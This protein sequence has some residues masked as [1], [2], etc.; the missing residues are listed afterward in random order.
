M[1]GP[2]VL[3]ALLRAEYLRGLPRAFGNGRR[4]DLLLVPV[5]QEPE[6]Q[7]AALGDLEGR[8]VDSGNASG[9]HSLRGPIVKVPCYLA[10]LH[11]LLL[12]F[13]G[14]GLDERPL[15]RGLLRV[16]LVDNYL[17]LVPVLAV[18]RRPVRIPVIGVR[19]DWPDLWQRA[20]VDAHHREGLDVPSV[21]D[22]LA[23]KYAVAIGAAEAKGGN[24][25]VACGVMHPGALRLE[26]GVKR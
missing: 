15:D 22:A 13:F 1:D 8:N 12:A 3:R 4:D 19:P 20:L 16:V 18:C 23:P 5:G 6:L 7:G 17:V 14:R 9:H 2:G 24:M 25:A 21:D 11:L 26:V 10:G